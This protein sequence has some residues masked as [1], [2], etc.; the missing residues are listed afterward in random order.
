MIRP[1]LRLALLA[2]TIIAL[3]AWVSGGKQYSG[4]TS[5]TF[6]NGVAPTSG[7]S[8]CVDTYI[9]LGAAS[10]DT[11]KNYGGS[12]SLKIA[13]P[14]AASGEMRTLIGFDISA[15]PDS[16]IIVKAQLMLY[17]GAP[18]ATLTLNDTTSIVVYRVMNPWTEG[19]G[20]EGSPTGAPHATAC[21]NRRKGQ[22]GAKWGT[23]GC[24]G[25]LTGNGGL[26]QWWP[27]TGLTARDSASSVSL[28]NYVGADTVY[29]GTIAMFG[30]TAVDVPSHLAAK[31]GF[32]YG[33]T[34]PRR[35][36]YTIIDVTHQ[37]H[38]WHIGANENNGFVLAMPP[39]CTTINQFG[40]VSSNATGFG[41]YRR[42]RLV[43]Y[44]FDPTSGSS[45]SGGRRVIGNGVGG[46]H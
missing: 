11:G 17:Q 24:K 40:F 31:G 12:D 21:W 15:L 7:Y 32:K 14:S 23:P 4:I 8:G 6:Q 41:L 18:N 16:A 19:T 1:I 38:L 2:G 45:G 26:M 29:S 27:G 3:C 33:A 42:P 28:S 30:S 46:L 39:Y 35:F 10:A 43:V 5:M 22:Q 20:T 25:S 13:G 36:G 34:G 44:Y 9:R 37:V